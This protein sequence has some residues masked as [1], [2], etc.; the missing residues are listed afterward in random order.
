MNVEFGENEIDQLTGVH[1]RIE[2]ERGARTAVMQP[3][4]ETIDKGCF[5]GADFAGKRDKPFAG[6]D[7]VHQ[8]RQCL[9]NFL[10]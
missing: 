4:Q 6:L 3:I 8:A 7:T 9:L 1:A 2:K 5:P 10:G